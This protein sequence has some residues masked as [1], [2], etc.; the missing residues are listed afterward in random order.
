[1]SDVVPA[2][3]RADLTSWLDFIV[4]LG[5]LVLFAGI[6]GALVFV[7]IP[8]KNETLFAGLSGSV[9]GASLTAYINWR[10]GA[11]SGSAAKDATIATMAANPPSGAPL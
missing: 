9:V 7:N 5:L 1:M 2:K 4:V 6:L 3:S 11:S 10:W 8:E